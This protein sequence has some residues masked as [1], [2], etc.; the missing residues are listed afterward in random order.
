MIEFLYL[1]YDI[2]RHIVATKGRGHNECPVETK[3]LLNTYVTETFY[4]TYCG[5]S[6]FA[7]FERIER[8]VLILERVVIVR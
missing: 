5:K 7:R 6:A 3:C 8:I 1:A 4:S 2:Q